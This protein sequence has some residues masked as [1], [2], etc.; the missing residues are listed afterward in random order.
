MKIIN[1]DCT[2]SDGILILVIAMCIILFAN[3]N[4]NDYDLYD[5]INNYLN[6]PQKQLIKSE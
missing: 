4:D 5:S 2:F 3:F 6:Q 1:K